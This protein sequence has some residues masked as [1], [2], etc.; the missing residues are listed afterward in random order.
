MA[1]KSASLKITLSYQAPGG[2][3][4]SFAPSTIT[5]PYSAQAE[6]TVDVPDTTA[7]AT[8]FPVPF[9]SIADGATMLIVQNNLDT[10]ITLKINGG[11]LENSIPA[12]KFGMVQVGDLGAAPITS[13]DIVTTADPQAGDG[14]VDCF[15]F[16]DPV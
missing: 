1:N 13:A 16:G 4:A 7:A 12:G 9:G 3:Q 2:S 11:D 5:I 6:S 10:A 14:S 8:V 15:V